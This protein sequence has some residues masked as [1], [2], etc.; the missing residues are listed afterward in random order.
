MKPN[1][2]IKY[3]S[4][5]SNHPP[6]VTKNLPKNIN[7]R[8]SKLSVDENVFNA[9]VEPYQTALDESGYNF[10]LK[11]DPQASSDQKK[12][13]IRK[14]KTIYFNPPWSSDVKTNIGQKFLE[15]VKSTFHEKHPLFKICNR[16]TMKISYSCLPNM[17]NE[18]SRQNKDILRPKTKDTGPLCNCRD[19]S[20][21]PIPGNCTTTSVVYMAEVRREDNGYSTTY[22]GL[23]GGSFKDRWQ[24]HQTSF[25]H[26]RYK[27]STKLSIYIWSLKEKNVPYS[28]KW[29]IIGRASTYNPATKKCR[30]CLLEKFFI[31]YH[32]AKSKLNQRSELFSKCLHKAK[33]LLYNQQK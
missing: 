6:A 18:I 25:R 30:L 11:F 19:K 14:R 29:S 24:G 8:L 28:I 3:V 16:N 5:F 27:N 7:N 32:P 1:N 22:T 33:N 2:V 20:K 31:L 12:K 17:R 26:E 10:K 23:T 21:C 15:I 13:R 4:K 9:A